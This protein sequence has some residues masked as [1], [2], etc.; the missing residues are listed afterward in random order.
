[1]P[2]WSIPR[3]TALLCAAALLASCGSGDGGSGNADPGQPQRGGSITVQQPFEPS[4]GL[5]FL[6]SDD[7]SLMQLLSGTVYSKLVEVKVGEGVEGLELV[8][9]LATDW[10]SSADGL[11]YTFNLRDDVKWQNIEPVNG[12]PFTADDVV[13]TFEGLKA[14]ESSHKWMAEPIESIT[15]EGD[16]RV[17]FKLKHAYAPFLE[18]MAHH[19]NVILPR[20]G[21]EGKFDM[22]EKAIGTGPFM[23]DSHKPDVEWVLKRNPDYYEEGKPYLDEIR[24]PIISDTS[25]VTAALRSGRLDVGTQPYDVIENTFAGNDDFSVIEV[26]SNFVSFD[27]NT[28]KKPFDDVRVRRAIMLAIDWEN[29]G[30]NT[31]GKINYTSL[32]RPEITSAALTGDEVREL[33]PYDPE[34]A[35]KLLAEAGYP[36]GFKTTIMV[37]KLS[38]SDVREG[39][40]IVADLKKVGIEAE[41][42]ILDP[43]TAIGRRRDQQYDL[44]K[45]ARAV[46]FPD[47]TVQD[48]RTGST[49]NYAAISDPQ[50]DKMIEESRRTLDEDDR[51]QIYRDFQER[52]ETEI[53]ASV[54]PIQYYQYWAVNSRVRDYYQSPIYHGRRYADMWVTGD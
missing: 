48:F 22:S 25:A 21:V 2:K 49:E 46:I 41:I 54:L 44:S 9:D 32:F 15:A 23:V 8:P 16:H 37:Q 34:R 12:R 10:E 31:R 42:Q 27:I 51:N 14:S 20:E 28:T 50:I 7:P 4:R 1:M 36:N 5:N 53:A 13:A 38:D 29:M 35:R 39:E 17:V 40:W 24:L 52:M 47:Q 6:V 33:R 3:L 30:K 18:Y 19:F 26:P 11:T 45:A 43:G